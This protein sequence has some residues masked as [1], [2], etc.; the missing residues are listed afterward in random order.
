MP[1]V[2]PRT[3]E[4][5]NLL[6]LYRDYCFGGSTSERDA[7]IGPLDAKN[8]VHRPRSFFCSAIQ[9]RSWSERLVSWVLER[10]PF[11]SMNVSVPLE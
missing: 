11:G 6:S 1:R 10:V 8:R 7:S 5:D 4:S 3:H 9:A 2:L